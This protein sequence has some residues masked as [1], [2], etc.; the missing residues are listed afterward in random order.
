ML[1]GLGGLVPH[2][3]HAGLFGAASLVPAFYFDSTVLGPEGENQVGGST[4]DP[5]SLSATVDYQQGGA[6]GT[7][8]H[9]GDP[10]ITIT[11]LLPGAPFCID[12]MSGDCLRQPD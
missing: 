9:I 2:Q 5:A 1:L 12:N 3:V 10:Q 6:D 11:N 7:L 8:I 4:A